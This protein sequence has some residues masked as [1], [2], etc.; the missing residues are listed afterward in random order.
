MGKDIYNIVLPSP[1]EV[2]FRQNQFVCDNAEESFQSSKE[3]LATFT[4]LTDASQ[5]L[6]L[7]LPLCAI[8]IISSVQI[9]LFYMW[10]RAKSEQC[11]GRSY[12]ITFIL[13]YT[14]KQ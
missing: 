13:L 2:A 3:E 10:S 8:V 12:Y 9:L 11:Q 6:R 1:V 5:W 7:A 4:N 14:K